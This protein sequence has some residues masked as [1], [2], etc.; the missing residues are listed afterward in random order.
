MAQLLKDIQRELDRLDK[1]EWYPTIVK[2]HNNFHDYPFDDDN[3][4]PAATVYQILK[5]LNHLDDMKEDRFIYR[6]HQMV[7]FTFRASCKVN[8]DTVYWNPLHESYSDFAKKCSGT[9][10]KYQADQE[11]PATDIIRSWLY[12]QIRI[13]S[14]EEQ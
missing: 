10:I 13:S 2:L 7:C 14:F 1:K 6:L 11:H 9:L 5:D 4:T 8:T 12:R 3:Q